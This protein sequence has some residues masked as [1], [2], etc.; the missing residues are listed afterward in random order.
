MDQQESRKDYLAGIGGDVAILGKQRSKL[1]PILRELGWKVV[2]E[3]EYA[4]VWKPEA[5]NPN[6]ESNPK[7]E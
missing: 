7:S 5:R 1:A 4:Q 6:G 2:F 3:D